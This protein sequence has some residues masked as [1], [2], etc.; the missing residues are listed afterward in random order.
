MPK[1][2]QEVEATRFVDNPHKKVV[3]LSALRG[4][5]F[6]TRENIPVTDFWY[7]LSDPRAIVRPKGYVNEK[8]RFPHRE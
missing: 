1:D 4:G 5:S 7:R 3:R 8:F 2:F 6:Y